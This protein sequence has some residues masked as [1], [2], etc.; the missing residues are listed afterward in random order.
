[1]N[2]LRSISIIA[3][4][5]LTAWVY[6]GC[7]KSPFHFD[8]SLF[9]ASSQITEP[10]NVWR[11]LNPAQGRQ[12]TYLTYFLNYRIGRANPAGY[13]LINLLLHLANVAVVFLFCR[14]ALRAYPDASRKTIHDGLPFGAA[15]V[16]AL[17]PV[18]S[19]SVNYIYQRATLL[20]ALF[21]LTSLTLFIA[22]DRAGSRRRFLMFSC[23]FY[24]CAVAS[25][26]SAL[27]LPLAFVAYFWTHA[28]NRG[29]LKKLLLGKRWLLLTQ[30]LLMIA[31]AGWTFYLFHRP[32]V[33]AAGFG[34]ANISPFRYSVT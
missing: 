27:V 25:K 3:T 24:I 21:S 33:D 17:H 1:M 12:L 30:A 31:G 7:L 19:E 28:E 15:A 4:L 9:L 32:G 18:Q 23:V 6:W 14:A 22:S 13:H 5:A 29:S 34:I 20:A 16:F 11:I 8:D 2:R 10:G 26:E